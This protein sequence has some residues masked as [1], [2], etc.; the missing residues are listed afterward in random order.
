MATPFA[1]ELDRLNQRITHLNDGIRRTN[2]L[3]G[4]I[5]VISIAALTG[6]FAYAYRLIRDVVQPDNVVA[7]AD[8]FVTE[9]LPSL[10]TSLEAQVKESAPRWAEQLSQQARDSIPQL[11]TNLEGY[12]LAQID[13]GIEQLDLVSSLR[14]QEFLEQHKDGLRENLKL[15]VSQ[16][17]LPEE[18]MKELVETLDASLETDLKAANSQLLESM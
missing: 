10:R 14:L 2:W 15:L 12:A 9:N 1:I 3:T 18:A 7:L 5:G 6:Y 16:D 13:E 8:E 11:R 4:L 17:Q